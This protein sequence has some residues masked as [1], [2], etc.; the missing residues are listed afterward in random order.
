MSYH[1]V[2]VAIGRIYVLSSA[3]SGEIKKWITLANEMQAEAAQRLSLFKEIP[4]GEESCFLDTTV[5]Q[6]PPEAF[7]DVTLAKENIPRKR[8]MRAL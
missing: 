4:K 5:Y 8:W 3:N 2:G 1:K 7:G 6:E